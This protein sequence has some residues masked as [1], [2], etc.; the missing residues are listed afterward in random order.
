ME[1]DGGIERIERG[2]RG[3]L[4]YGSPLTCSYGTSIEVYESS[5][6]EGPHAWL[7][8]RQGDRSEA[9]AHLSEEQARALVARLSAWLEDIPQRW[10]AA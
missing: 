9:F 10:G 8:M 6:A 4:G 7:K 1:N 2:D 3:F 5:S